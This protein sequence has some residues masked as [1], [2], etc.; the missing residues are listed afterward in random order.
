MLLFNLSFGCSHIAN[1]V[2]KKYITNEEN[3]IIETK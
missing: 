1:D 2:K 3:S